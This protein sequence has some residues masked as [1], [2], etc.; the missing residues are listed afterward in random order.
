MRNVWPGVLGTEDE[1]KRKSDRQAKR[2]WVDCTKE[3]LAER[4]LEEWDVDDRH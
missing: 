2:R 3:D 1:E 4:E